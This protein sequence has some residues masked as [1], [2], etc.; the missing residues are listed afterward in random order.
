MKE[1]TGRVKS[2]EFDTGKV[3]IADK[4]KNF[5]YVRSSS[6]GDLC[7]LVVRNDYVT[8]ELDGRIVESFKEHSY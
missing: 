2:I 8:F 1:F 5:F 4:E 7:A 6:I 3:Q